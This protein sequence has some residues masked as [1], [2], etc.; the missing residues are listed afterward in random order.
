MMCSFHGGLS[1]TL[2]GDKLELAKVGITRGMSRSN[3]GFI[4]KPVNPP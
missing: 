2:E 3:R 1:I 4:A